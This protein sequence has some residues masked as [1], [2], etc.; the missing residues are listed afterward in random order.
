[1]RKKILKF[2]PKR[3][4]NWR[5]RRFRIFLPKRRENG[6]VGKKTKE[7]RIQIGL[8]RYVR[9]IEGSDSISRDEG[10][11]KTSEKSE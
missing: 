11:A 7:G 10:G 4:R 3:T 8:T 2:F 6:G 1:M 9:L 5:N